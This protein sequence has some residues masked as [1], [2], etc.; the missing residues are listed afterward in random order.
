MIV[1]IAFPAYNE[2]SYIG[3]LVLKAKRYA[4]EVV[5]CD[6]GSNN[7][8]ASV[9][10]LAGATVLSY[11]VNRGKG[12]A[13]Q[14][15][16]EYARQFL[17]DVLVLLDADGQ[18]NPDEIPLLINAVLDGYDLVIGSRQ[19]DIKKAPFY[20]RIG[21]GILSYSTDAVAGIKVTKDSQSGF[22]ALSRKAISEITILEDGFAVETEMIVKALEKGLK[23]T[24]VP[25]SC[26]YTRDG[27]TLNPIYHG[28]G[29][30]ERMVSMISERRPLFFF[31]GVGVI[32]A[33]LGILAG[34]RVVETVS[35]FGVIP[36]GSALLSVF[37]IMMA[38]L[39]IF[40]G[41][42]LHMLTKLLR[43]FKNNRS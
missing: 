18:H 13:I 1:I 38:T 19:A 32:M 8:T 37:L 33:I 41:T 4:D 22:R 23:I 31:G 20:R 17:P 24:E 7:G 11:G 35:K 39:C 6:D 10:R 36:I 34:I 9:A 25:I 27:S 43:N 5:V 15:I 21:Q 16:L 14:R 12:F 42:I 40:A 28:L 3:S 2:E 29:V 30:M 26:I